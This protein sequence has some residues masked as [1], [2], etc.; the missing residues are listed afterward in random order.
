MNANVGGG[1]SQR[2]RHLSG[3]AGDILGGDVDEQVI[4]VRPL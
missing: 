3:N 4:F 1:N 2:L